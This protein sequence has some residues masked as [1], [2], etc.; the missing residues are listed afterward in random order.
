[1]NLSNLKSSDSLN[2]PRK[3]IT[4]L[5]HSA[6]MYTHNKNTWVGSNTHCQ[7]SSN[8]S[9]MVEKHSVS[10]THNKGSF[11]LVH[12]D[13]PSMHSVMQKNQDSSVTQQI[14]S[15]LVDKANKCF[16]VKEFFKMF[17]GLLVIVIHSI[18]K[19][20]W[21]VTCNVE[22]NGSLPPEPKGIS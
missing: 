5:L 14:Y 21:N 2:L 8:S 10:F 17:I 20:L 18:E 3:I 4:N 19:L 7:T 11:Y 1:M 12:C 13:P 15:L 9:Y 6:K 22:S 16:S